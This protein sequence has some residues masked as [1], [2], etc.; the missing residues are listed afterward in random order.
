MPAIYYHSHRIGT[1]DL[2]QLGHA[3]N[4]AFLRWMQSAAVKHS[5]AQGWPTERYL[6]LGC[7]WV[8][9]SHQIEYLQPGMPDQEIVVKTWVA[10]MQKVT[11]LRRYHIL[12]RA[13]KKEILLAEAATNWAFIHYK[14]G[15]PKRIPPEVAACFVVVPEI[16]AF[17]LA[18][19]EE[20]NREP[21]SSRPDS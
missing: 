17:E 6:E 20:S 11:S 3:N 2:D 7:G 13:E 21:S 8:V 15:M 19:R 1:D 12:R 14:S 10:D 18:S 5:A 16:D 9:R 4:L